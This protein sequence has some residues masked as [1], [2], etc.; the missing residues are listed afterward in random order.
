MRIREVKDDYPTRSW[1]EKSILATGQ[2]SG[3]LL[4]VPLGM[5]RNWFHHNTDV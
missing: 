4:E 3:Q 1:E 5:L 2:A